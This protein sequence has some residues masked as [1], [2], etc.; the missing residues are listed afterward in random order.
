LNTPA[1]VPLDR[2]YDLD[3]YRVSSTRG[4]DYAAAYKDLKDQGLPDLFWSTANGG[5]WVGTRA[6]IIERVFNEH[7]TFSARL[8]MAPASRNLDPP[9]LPVQADPPQWGKYRIFFNTLLSPK[10]VAILSVTARETAIRLIE[11]LENKG[12]CDFIAE[13][14]YHLP[15]TIFMQIAGLPAQDRELVLDL[16]HTMLR[17]P[18]EQREQRNQ[19]HQRLGAYALGK[20]RERRANPGDDA[21][22]QLALG[23]VDGELIPE[24]TLVGIVM[25]LLLA[26]LDTV[27]G[28]MGFFMWHLAQNPPQRRFLRDHPETIPAAVEELL[29]RFAITTNAR[30]LTKDIEYDG[31]TMKAGEIIAIPAPLYNLDERRYPNPREIDFERK[32]RHVTFGG[33]VHRCAGAH[34]ARAELKILLEE[35]LQRIPDFELAPD[36]QIIMAGNAVVSVTTLP[37]VW[38]VQ[39]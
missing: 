3:V 22:S 14:S 11:G 27:A 25:L 2:V 26:G 19:V 17:T 38:K 5:H 36:A 23:R 18:E 10:Q 15:I 34:L 31:V 33:G 37:L 28:M 6:E 39:D 12:H 8:V 9:L 21:I 20:I 13:F 16:V 29:R 1:H 32:P 7:E 24:H 35:W 4:K 30:V